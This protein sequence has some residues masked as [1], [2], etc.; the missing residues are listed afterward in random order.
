MC[1]DC[2]CSITHDHHDHSFKT[3][4]QLN[5][6]KTLSV[7]HKILSKN[8]LEAIAIENNFKLFENCRVSS[9]KYLLTF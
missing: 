7:I 8:D 9:K 4:P 3:N 1:Q 6:K 2:G 5:D